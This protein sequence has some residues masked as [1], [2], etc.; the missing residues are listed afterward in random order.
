[1]RLVHLATWQPC[2][3]TSSLQFYKWPN[4]CIGM[5]QM[6]WMVTFEFKLLWDNWNLDYYKLFFGGNSKKNGVNFLIIT[7]N[8]QSTKCVS[9]GIEQR[10]HQISL[11]FALMVTQCRRVRWS[12][13]YDGLFITVTSVWRCHFIGFNGTLFQKKLAK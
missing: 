8:Y 2:Q 10:I 5:C 4:V 11:Q 1:M 9:K 6:D 3:T 12:D 13:A 7:L